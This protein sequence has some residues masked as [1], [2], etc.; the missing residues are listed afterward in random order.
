M[1]GS[2]YSTYELAR[3]MAEDKMDELEED[4]FIC[5]CNYKSG[6]EFVLKTRGQMMTGGDYLHMVKLPFNHRFRN[7]HNVAREA[8]RFSKE[9]NKYVSIHRHTYEENGYDKFSHF[10]LCLT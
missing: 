6:K 3:D 5:S 2:V 4:I 7:K 1:T 8:E 10:T 9:L